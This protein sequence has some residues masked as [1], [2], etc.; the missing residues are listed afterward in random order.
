M[1]PELLD[2][3]RDECKRILRR[4]ELEAYSATVSAFR[5]QGDLSKE[6]KRL[7]L[8]LQNTLSIST[9]RHR[10]EIRRAVNDEKLATIAD[11]VAGS[12]AISEWLIEGRRLIPIMPRLVPQTAFTVTANQAAN[13]QAEKNASLPSP[14]MTTIKDVGVSATTPPQSNSGGGNRL[15]RPSSPTSNVVVLPSGMSIHIK[16]GLNTEDDEDVQVRKR[17][18]STSTESL[19]S[20]T[21]TPVHQVTFTTTAASSTS[22]SPMKITISKSPQGQ[23]RVVTSGSQTQKVI[24]VSSGGG[25]QSTPSIIHKSITVPIVK[26]ASSATQVSGG[27]NKSIIFPTSTAA[28]NTS[29]IVTVTARSDVQTQ[30]SCTST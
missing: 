11:N 15:S 30:S 6:K 21:G 28:G 5:A 29:N 10:A 1:W 2:M 4:I 9:E 19:V 18:R 26:T 17:R 24:V 12:N 25:G 16:G 3:T 20:P 13:L 14:S 27:P 8:D 22:M 7:L 23:P